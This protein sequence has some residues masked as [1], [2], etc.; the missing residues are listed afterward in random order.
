MQSCTTTTTSKNGQ[1]F[2][3]LMESKIDGSDKMFQSNMVLM[4]GNSDALLKGRSTLK[5]EKCQQHEKDE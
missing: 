2:S 3:K 5:Q 1:H 4:E